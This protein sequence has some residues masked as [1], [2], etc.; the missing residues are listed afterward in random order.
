MRPTE[1]EAQLNLR[2]VLELCAAGEVRCS[3]SLA[4]LATSAGLATRD[5]VARDVRRLDSGRCV[6]PDAGTANPARR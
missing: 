5:R 4:D 3:E 6:I 1:R 2:M